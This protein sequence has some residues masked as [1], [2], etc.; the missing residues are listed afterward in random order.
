MA[1]T[2]FQH[3]AICGTNKACYNLGHITLSVGKVLYRYTSVDSIIQNRQV[4]GTNDVVHH[5]NER[6]IHRWD[7]GY[8]YDMWKMYSLNGITIISR[9]GC[10]LK[11]HHSF[12]FILRIVF[13][14]LRCISVSG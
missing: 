9:L 14:Y 6:G 2:H 7:N 12:T 8:R 10:I 1:A 5:F 11:V 4:N 13:P 3:R